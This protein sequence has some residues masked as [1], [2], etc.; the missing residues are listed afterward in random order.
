M[1]CIYNLQNPFRFGCV[2]DSRWPLGIRQPKQEL[3]RGGNWFFLSRWPLTICSSPRG[4]T[5]W[6]FPLSTLA[7]PLVLS[8]CWPCSDDRIV[9]S[10]PIHFPCHVSGTVP[11]SR[12]SEPLALTI[13]SHLLRYSKVGIFFSTLLILENCLWKVQ[14]SE[15]R[16]S[17]SG[18]GA[19]QAN[20]ALPDSQCICCSA[21]Q[22]SLSHSP[23][24]L[25][26]GRHCLHGGW[27][28]DFPCPKALSRKAV[29]LNH[30]ALIV[31][32]WP[33]KPT[34]SPLVPS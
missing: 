5:I 16:Y 28:D 3:I 32:P 33:W 20:S 24:V 31:L 25:D 17:C 8:L 9:E 6:G 19:T 34:L 10:S 26:K 13:L 1:T 4:G 22:F 15:L 30:E 14:G 12:C 2:C 23:M 21:G 27:A 29:Q 11:N 7:C 18:S